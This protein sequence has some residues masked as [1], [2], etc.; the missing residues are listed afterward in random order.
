MS[1]KILETRIVS[2]ND[3]EAN[4]IENDPVLMKGELAITNPEPLAE[5]GYTLPKFK[6]GM[7][8][9]KKWSEIDYCLDMNDVLNRINNIK[10]TADNTYFTDNLTFT[11][12]FGKYTP[13]GGN[14]EVPT[15]DK[16][17]SE[18]FLD[19]FAE[20]KDPSI[21]QPAAEITLSYTSE[22]EVGTTTSL[23]VATLK[24]TSVGTATYGYKDGNDVKYAATDASGI[25]FAVGDV[26]LSEG[27]DNT[28]SN[29]SVMVKNST[30]SLTADNADGTTTVGFGDTAVTYTF[31]GTAHCTESDRVPINNLGTKVPGKQITSKDITVTSKTATFT[32]YR[33]CFWGYV[34]ADDAVTITNGDGTCALTSAFV[35][36]DTAGDVT[37]LQN[38]GKSLPSSYVVPDKTKQVFFVAPKN[39]YTKTLSLKDE[40][41]L[42]APVACKKIASALAVNGANSYTAA[43]YDLWYVNLDGA[44]DGEGKIILTWA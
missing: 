43:D 17:I 28:V 12:Q 42:N 19:A 5:G 26:T 9:I 41:A 29:T 36:D 22:G 8:G 13:S 21:G 27:T 3:S 32:G 35:R 7:D 14:V 24:I 16:S 38:S 11:Y 10:P 34:L 37:H 39:K 25:T 4:W 23:P 15:K 40:Y 20:A 33:K 18:V 30:I 2:R 44:F 1:E 31:T 6:V